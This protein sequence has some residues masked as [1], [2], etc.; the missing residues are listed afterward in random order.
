MA[1]KPISTYNRLFRIRT[2]RAITG[3]SR[4][5]LYNLIQEGEFPAPV[6]IGK[7]S[8]AWRESD[9]Q[10]WGESLQVSTELAGGAAK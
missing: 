7:R 9:I 3:L 8:S 5:S 1:N 4:T 10:E 6:K 2:V